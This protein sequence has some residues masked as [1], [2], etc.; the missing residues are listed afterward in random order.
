MILWT[1]LFG[2]NL[3]IRRVQYYCTIVR[4]V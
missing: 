1:F 4:T 2:K 3:L